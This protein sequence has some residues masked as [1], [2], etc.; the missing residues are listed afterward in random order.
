LCIDNVHCFS[1][2]GGYDYYGS[3]YGNYGGYGGYDYTGYGG[4]GNY[5][6]YSVLSFNL[7]CG[8]LWFPPVTLAECR[9]YLYY[10]FNTSISSV[11]YIYAV[12]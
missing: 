4:Y 10:I 8:L 6:N 5:G 12:W 7:I 2:Y 1:G 11:K 9:R 3:G